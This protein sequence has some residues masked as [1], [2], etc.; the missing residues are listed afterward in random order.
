LSNQRAQASAKV[1]PVCIVSP[2]PEPGLQPGWHPTFNGDFLVQIH[3]YKD[4]ISS[5]YT[6]CYQ[7]NWQINTQMSSFIHKKN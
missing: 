4:P 7:M 3:I 2:Y 5:Y 1:N 6:S